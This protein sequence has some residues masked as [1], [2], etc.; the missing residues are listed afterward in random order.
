MTCLSRIALLPLFALLV[1]CTAAV[2]APDH[3]PE[4]DTQIAESGESLTVYDDDL[5]GLWRP[6]IDGALQWAPSMIESWPAVGIRLSHQGAQ[7]NLTR[8]GDT[9]SLGLPPVSLAIEANTYSL[10]DDKMFGSVDGHQVELARDTRNKAPIVLKLPGDRPFRSFLIEQLMPAAQQDRESYTIFYGSKLRTFL[11]SCEL[12]K[13]G[14]LQYKFIKGNTWGERSYNLLS[15]TYAVD[16]LKTTP[17]RLIKEKRFVDSVKQNLKDESL[18]GLALS[19]F[20]MYFSTGAGRSI[21]IPITDDS[22]A[23]FITDRPNRKT[24]IGL[25]MMDTPLHGPLASTFGRQLLDFGAMLET[26]DDIYARTMME[27]LAKSDASRAVQLSPAGRSALTDWFAVMAIEDYRGMAFGI[28]NLGWGYNFT[29]VQF[30]GLVAR[31]L[32]RPGET[33]S[34]GSPVRSQVVVGN[35]LRP[36]DASY[37]DVLNNGNDMREYTDMANLKQLATEY[38]RAK[39]PGKVLDVEA[40]FANVIPKSQLDYRAQ[41]DI[42]HFISAQLYDSQGRTANLTG[43]SADA[44]VD[45]VTALLAALRADSELFEAYILSKGYVKSNDPAPKSTGY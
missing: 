1:N 26:D 21:R 28:P 27:M 30:Y 4:G 17:R 42:F 25:V 13:S 44:A 33:D 18:T 6:R 11:K 38:L 32:A 34:A 35:Q 3:E 10:F 23:Y 45:S 22:L 2:S 5:N 16:S 29:N 43:A 8:S 24:K 19:T 31:A 7:Y 15:I 40:A 9:L 39:H 37:A 12:Y 41:K 36:G 20:S 14:Y